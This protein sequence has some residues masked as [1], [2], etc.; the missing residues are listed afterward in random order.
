MTAEIKVVHTSDVRV[1]KNGKRYRKVV[2]I[3][4]IDKNEFLDI[5]YIYE[6]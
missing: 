5:R 3:T 6:N 2:T 1:S 4:T